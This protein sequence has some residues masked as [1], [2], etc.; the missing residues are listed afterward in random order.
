MSFGVGCVSSTLTMLSSLRPVGDAIVSWELIGIPFPALC[1]VTLA[2]LLARPCDR[3]RAW[4][5]VLR[6]DRSRRRE[7]IVA[8]RDRC[9]KR[10]ID[11]HLDSR[12]DRCAVLAKA[13]VIRG[14]RA[15]T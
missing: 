8:D 4:R 5:N 11:T 7:G 12:S 15:G 14:Q 9:N 6:N 10:G 13:V 3:E 2:V 1:R